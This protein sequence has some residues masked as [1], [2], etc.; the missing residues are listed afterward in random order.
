MG[1]IYNQIDKCEIHEDK[2]C[3]VK[4]R[5]LY[6]INKWY[7]YYVCLI[8][9]QKEPIMENYCEYR[10]KQLIKELEINCLS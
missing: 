1:S 4:F 2:G 10:K 7:D 8:Y 5:Y 9:D 3:C 6:G